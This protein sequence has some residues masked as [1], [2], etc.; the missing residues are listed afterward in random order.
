MFPDPHHQKTCRMLHAGASTN[1]GTGRGGRASWLN[2]AASAELSLVTEAGVDCPTR[3][4]QTTSSSFRCVRYRVPQLSTLLLPEAQWP[5]SLGMR[6]HS[7][8]PTPGRS[9]GSCKGRATAVVPRAQGGGATAVARA[10][11][12]VFLSLKFGR[13]RHHPRCPMFC[14]R[15]R[16]NPHRH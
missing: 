14:V 8:R 6:S 10:L 12:R 16:T 3:Q 9:V 11:Q 5:C 4:Q 7:D 1:P 2:D 15:S 13:A